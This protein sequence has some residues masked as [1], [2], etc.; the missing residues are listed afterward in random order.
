MDA[1]DRQAGIARLEAQDRGILEA[2][3]SLLP[4]DVKEGDLLLQSG[5]TYLPDEAATAAR[6]EK[7]QSLF[8]RLKK[9]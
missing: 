8:D 4:A 1:I 3:L 7:V 5:E 2:P 6:K 9:H